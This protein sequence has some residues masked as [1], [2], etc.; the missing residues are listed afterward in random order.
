MVMPCDLRRLSFSHTSRRAW[1]SRPVVGSSR[2]NIPGSLI[3]ALA[4][5]SLLLMPPDSSSGRLSALSRSWN[6]SSPSNDRCW[7]IDLGR[8]KYL[9]CAMRFWITLRSGSR[10]SAWDTT[11]MRA[12]MSL[13]W[14]PTS[15]PKTVRLPSVTGETHAII[16][17]VEVL[18]APFGPRK[19]KHSPG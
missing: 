4:I 18:P 17:M 19:P 13:L 10:L 15:M 5:R 9:P 2:T 1:G 16:F 3:S 6:R 14:L 8:L 12:L 11:P 7:A